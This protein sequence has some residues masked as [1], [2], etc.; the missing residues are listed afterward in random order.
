MPRRKASGKETDEES[1][2]YSDYNWEELYKLGNL[3]KLKVAELNKYIFCHNL[4][5]RKTSKSDKLL[6]AH[7]SKGLC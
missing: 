1:K 7:I 5:R 6:S 3:K 4:S 2:G